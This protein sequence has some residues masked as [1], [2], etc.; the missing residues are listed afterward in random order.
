MFV[1]YKQN[2][3]HLLKNENRSIVYNFIVTQSVK[4]YCKQ[5]HTEQHKYKG[6]SISQQFV[7]NIYPL[8]NKYFK[9]KLIFVY[10]K[11]QAGIMRSKN[12]FNFS[13]N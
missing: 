10:I 2:P 9:N 8:N 7:D 4:L 3:G 12:C 5:H 6:V 11:Q 13:L 1:K